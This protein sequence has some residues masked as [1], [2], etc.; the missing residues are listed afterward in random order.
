MLTI[1]CTAKLLKRI[2]RKPGLPDEVVEPTT[3]LGDWHANVLFFDRAQA[4]LF[5]NDNSR[6]AVVTSARDARNLDAHLAAEL[7]ELL[8][9]LGVPQPWINAEVAQMSQS[10]VA[11][12]R[13][14]SVLA[15]MNDYAFQIE[16]RFHQWGGLYP[17]QMS[18]DLSECPSG[19][20]G[21][22]LPYEVT[23]ALL[24]ERHGTE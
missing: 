3:A 1:R 21:Y 5:A 4:L 15:T 12:T 8:E 20:L 9:H 10:H 2:G 22:R 7:A 24:R 14:R 18:L 6:L 17:L 19:P 13:S 23:M 11:P 16:G